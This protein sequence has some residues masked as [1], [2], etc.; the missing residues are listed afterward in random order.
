MPDLSYEQTLRALQGMIGKSVAVT[1]GSEEA[2]F[3]AAAFYGTLYGADALDLSASMTAVPPETDE[4]LA[5]RVGHGRDLTAGSF[6]LWR[7]GF[8]W[9]GDD[10]EG[11]VLVRIGGLSIRVVP[12]APP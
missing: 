6:V 3:V 5:F 8:E 4:W 10:E 7:Q 11:G 9:A 1:V 2:S 12:W